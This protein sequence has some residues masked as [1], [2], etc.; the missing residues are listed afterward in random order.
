MNEGIKNQLESFDNH[1][2]GFALK[3]SLAIQEVTPIPNPF[4]PT[5]TLWTRQGFLASYLVQ[6]VKK[7]YLK[8]NSNI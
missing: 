5:L 6:K 2:S 1:Q 3:Q 7:K 8:S 4:H